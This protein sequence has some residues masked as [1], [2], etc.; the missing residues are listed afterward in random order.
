MINR[1]SAWLLVCSGLL[2]GAAHARQNSA[3]RSARAAYDQL[4]Y[5]QAIALGQEALRQT[6]S[7]DE[8]AS[9]YE[10]L[11]LSFGALDS[12][13]Q[14]IQA[15]EQLILI[16]PDREPDPVSVSPKITALYSQALG[17]MLVVRNV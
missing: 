1:V 11:G 14:A 8:R 6:I 12:T 10:I 5:E 3:V 16:D 4:E 9:A 13:G 17:R 2:C 7:R 15:F